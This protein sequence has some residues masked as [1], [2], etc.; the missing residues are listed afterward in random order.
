MQLT[1]PFYLGVKEVTNGEF[2]RFK[3]SHTSGAIQGADL[4]DDRQPVVMV[5]WEDAVAYLNWLSEQEGISEEQWCY[6]RNTDG[7]FASGMK[8]PFSTH[9]TLSF[10]W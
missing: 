4:D 1:R 7:N 9:V 2:R 3:A 6:E 5:A 8:P 10:P